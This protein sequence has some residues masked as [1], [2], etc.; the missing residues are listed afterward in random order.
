M[1]IALM[2][3]IGIKERRWR[4]LRHKNIL[5]LLDAEDF[6]TFDLTWFLSPVAEMTLEEALKKRIFQND[7]TVL[8][9][10]V[11]WIREVTS[12]LHY[13]HKNELSFFNLKLSNVRSSNK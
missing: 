6:P 13:L 4:Q 11:S 7:H 3:D 5:P 8:K 2:E 10:L 1:R 9:L 12:A